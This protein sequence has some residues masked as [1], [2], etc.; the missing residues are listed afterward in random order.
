LAILADVAPYSR[1]YNTY[2]QKVGA[3]TKDNTELR[4]QYERILDRVRQTRE[5]IIKMNDR[6][7]TAP[8]DEISGTVDEVSAGGITLKEFPGR[9]FQFSSVGLSAADMSAAAL[10][11]HNNLNRSL[12]PAAHQNSHAPASRKPP[13]VTAHM[14][15]PSMQLDSGLAG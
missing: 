8:V 14:P 12:H 15:S 9:R 3:Q 1:E 13:P 6:H 7:F 11:E 4:I 2:R 10:G 5:S